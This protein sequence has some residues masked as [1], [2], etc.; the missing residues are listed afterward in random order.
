M[1]QNE[2]SHACWEGHLHGSLESF[3]HFAF[4]LEKDGVKWSPSQHVREFE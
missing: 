1:D 2:H 4:L 3:K